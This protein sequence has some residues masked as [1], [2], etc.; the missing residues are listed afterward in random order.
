[1]P[2]PF[3][4]VRLFA[5]QWT[6]FATHW[7][8]LSRGF[9]QARILKWVAVP[10]SSGI[11][12]TQG[13]NTHLLCLLHWQVGSLPP[14]PPGK[15]QKQSVDVRYIQIDA[16]GKSKHVLTNFLPAP[17]VHL[18]QSDVEFSGYDSGLAYSFLLLCQSF[19]PHVF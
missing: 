3:S 7:A 9:L 12:P 1:M 4:R 14:A 13:S 19:L 2:S 15:P 5:M 16:V 17:S 6:V 10:S 18:C 8:L 11:S